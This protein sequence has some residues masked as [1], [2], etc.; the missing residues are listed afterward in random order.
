MSENRTRCLLGL[1]L[2]AAIGVKTTQS[3]PQ[4]ILEVEENDMEETSTHWK[5]FY[6]NKYK[7]IFTRLGRSKSHRVHTVFKQPLTP[8]QEKDRRVPI[9]IQEK[10]GE[11]IKRLI[12]EG[13]IVKLNKCTSKFFVAPVVI[14]AKKDG[15]V[16]IAMDA[17]LMNAQIFK[18]Q[19]QMPNLLEQ[20]DV[21]AQT[22]NSSLPSEVLFT[23]LDLKFAFSQLQLSDSVRNHC[24][25]NIVC[26]DA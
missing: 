5:N 8:I 21:A 22:I 3:R 12:K 10:V 9:Q 14:T 25:C 26:G 15:S 2:Q 13:Y 23:S 19:Y 17:R 11:E 6:S 7:D 1:D 4:E 24:N 20:L 16:K 18:N